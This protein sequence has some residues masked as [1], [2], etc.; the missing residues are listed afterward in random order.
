MRYR[1]LPYAC[2]TLKQDL[3][4]IMLTN[5]LTLNDISANTMVDTLYKAQDPVNLCCRLQVTNLQVLYKT[6]APLVMSVIVIFF[7][8][9][10]RYHENC[11]PK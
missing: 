8:S 6:V 9:G 5:M 11:L 4:N 7:I 3:I 2:T 10:C 1:Y